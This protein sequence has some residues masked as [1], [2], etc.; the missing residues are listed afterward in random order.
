[1]LILKR[2]VI[3]KALRHI[4]ELFQLAPSFQLGTL[5][6]IVPSSQPDITLVSLERYS[7]RLFVS[8]A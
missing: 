6:L 7:L 4:L 5:L 1:M 3:M 2:R 8:M